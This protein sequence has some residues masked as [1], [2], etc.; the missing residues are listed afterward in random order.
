MNNLHFERFYSQAGQES[1]VLDETSFKKDG[2][3]LDIGAENGE[4]SSN[5]LYLEEKYGWKGI[6][7]EPNSSAF[8]R[9]VDR[10]QPSIN[11]HC[12]VSNY[13]GNC[14]FTGDRIQDGMDSEDIDC[15]TLYSLLKTH[16]APQHIDYMSIDVEGH[17]LVILEKYF[18]END[19]YNIGLMT[20]EH[21][22]YGAGCEAKDKIFDLLCKNGYDRVVED[23]IVTAN[24]GWYGLP[25][26]DWYKKGK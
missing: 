24:D 2:Y 21:N 14:R 10:R 15:F 20:V 25:Y 1:W 23:A 5:T 6:C 4:A 9:L 12:A 7:A 3:F 26:E 13:N 22:L 19:Y 18:E 17:E 16:N 8:Q 11:V